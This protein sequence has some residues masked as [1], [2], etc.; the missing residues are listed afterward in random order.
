MVLPHI[1]SA[2]LTFCV[3]LLKRDGILERC[4]VRRCVLLKAPNL[5]LGCKPVIFVLKLQ[6]IVVPLEPLGI[7]DSFHSLPVTLMR[8]SESAGARVA[9]GIGLL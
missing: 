1:L 6:L 7:P 9:V 4:F 5:A 2:E 8:P 3:M